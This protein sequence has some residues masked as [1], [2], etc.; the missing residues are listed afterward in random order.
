MRSYHEKLL[1]LMAVDDFA[2]EEL[3]RTPTSSDAKSTKKPAAR[4]KAASKKTATAKK[5]AAK[6][7]SGTKKAKKKA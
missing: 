3:S 2:P 1:S 7:M 4:K 6:S 5:V